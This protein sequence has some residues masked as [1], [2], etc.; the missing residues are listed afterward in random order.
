MIFC[1]QI[2]GCFAKCNEKRLTSDNENV[3]YPTIKSTHQLVTDSGRFPK[4]SLSAWRS[5]LLSMDF[6]LQR[7]SDVDNAFLIESQ[8]I[9]D[10]R[11]VY[12]LNMQQHRFEG[13]PIYCKVF[14]SFILIFVSF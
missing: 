6:R 12:L 14:L 3:T 11:E 9:I 2:H 13:R 7:N 8:H 4:W 5:I 10:W 1:F